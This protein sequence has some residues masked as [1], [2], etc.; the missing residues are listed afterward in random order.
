MAHRLIPVRLCGT[1]CL[2]YWSTVEN[3]LRG[4]MMRQDGSSEEGRTRV[5]ILRVRT[6]GAGKKVG[7]AL[8]AKGSIT[9]GSWR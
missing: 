5:G 3:T 2:G 4:A 9:P 1:I 7:E 6:N 8:V